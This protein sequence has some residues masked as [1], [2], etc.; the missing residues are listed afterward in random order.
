MLLSTSQS[1]ILL[2]G[3][4]GHWIQCRRGLR[5]GDPLSP[6]LFILLADTLQRLILQAS[7]AGSIQRL[8]DILVSFS[9][10]SGLHINFDKSVGSHTSFWFD[11]WIDDC[12][13]ANRFPALFSHSTRVNI[14]VAHAISS[15]DFH[16]RN[17]LSSV[18]SSELSNLLDLLSLIQLTPS[19]TDYCHLRGSASSP[20]ST[21]ACYSFAF[22]HLPSDLF[23]DNNWKNLAPS[24]C[25]S[26]LWQTHHH[27]INTNDR[28]RSRRANNSGRCH[29]CGSQEDV[30]HLFL[31]CSRAQYFWSRRRICSNP[32]VTSE[33]LDL[34]LPLWMMYSYLL[35][36]N[37]PLW[38]MYAYLNFWI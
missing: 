14:S 26:F 29:F 27:K 23:A 32:V 13:L 11:R 35:G 4:P 34:E 31:H 19:D 38:L 25:R 36:M 16:L 2:N 15:G 10:F 18:A 21:A 17:R 28:L 1:A 37:I 8:K 5:Q 6:Y 20:F 12:V 7:A 33:I 9:S 22:A 3:H 30:A 24:H